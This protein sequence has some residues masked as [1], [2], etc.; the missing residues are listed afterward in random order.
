LSIARREVKA[1]MSP[2]SLSSYVVIAH[3]CADRVPECSEIQQFA[4]W[5]AQGVIHVQTKD[6]IQRRMQGSDVTGQLDIEKRRERTAGLA[7]EC[8]LNK[9]R[10]TLRTLPAGELEICELHKTDA[11]HYILY[12]TDILAMTLMS[13][14]FKAASHRQCVHVYVST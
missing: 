6:S 1:G 9:W 4:L 3:G 8:N 12:H 7:E 5:Y 11:K 2:M 13:T 10:G 14:R